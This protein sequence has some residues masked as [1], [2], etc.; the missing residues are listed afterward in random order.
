LGI[1]LFPLYVL[2]RGWAH[3]GPYL[4]FPLMLKWL[5][6]FFFYGVGKLEPVSKGEVS[7]P[8][9][10]RVLYSLDDWLSSRHFL[11]LFVISTDPLSEN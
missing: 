11:V 7:L 6:L 1:P 4:F 8:L 2:T 3:R 10:E 9:E 5:A